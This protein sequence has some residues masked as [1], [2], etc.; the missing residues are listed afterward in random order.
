[1]QMITLATG[2]LGA[3]VG[4]IASFLANLRIETVRGRNKDRE[5]RENLTLAL[6]LEFEACLKCLDELKGSLNTSHVYLFRWTGVL[7]KG[8]QNLDN[9][10]LK[11]YL[12]QNAELQEKVLSL[13]TDISLLI[14]DIEVVERW[15][16]NLSNKPPIGPNGA[17]ISAEEQAVQQEQIKEQRRLKL[18][19][20]VDLKRRLGEITKDLS[21]K[22]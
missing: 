5:E 19:E 9:L 14:N 10:R 12:L 3:I 6:K 1:M 17:P 8:T 16:N 13:T 2:L 7:T 20:L 15:S 18:V 11:L 22:H 21:L 4:A